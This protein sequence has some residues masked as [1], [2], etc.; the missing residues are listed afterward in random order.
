MN[1]E[2]SPN[3][4]PRACA[5][6]AADLSLGQASRREI[7]RM[8]GMAPGAP[9]GSRLTAAGLDLPSYSIHMIQPYP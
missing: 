2:S 6:V 1:I 4:A 8:V 7:A 5:Q 9:K 3:R